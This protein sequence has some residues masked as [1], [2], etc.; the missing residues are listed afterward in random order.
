MEVLDQ[1]DLG[2]LVPSNK[3]GDTVY[4]SDS[5]KIY[6]GMIIRQIICNYNAIVGVYYHV[7]T[8]NGQN[9]LIMQEALLPQ[10]SSSFL[11]IDFSE[12][13]LYRMSLSMRQF[14]ILFNG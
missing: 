3:I 5:G 1:E 2:L 7:K 11:L 10:Q 6:A 12:E 8:N 9:H 14:S 13:N 4:Y